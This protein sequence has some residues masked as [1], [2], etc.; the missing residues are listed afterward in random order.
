MINPSIYKTLPFDIFSDFAAV[1][2][3]GI[4]TGYL[5]IVNPKV[6]AEN[7]G[8]F[9]AYA[10]SH[11]V[12]YGSAGIGNTLH[13][14]AELLNAKAGIAMEHVPFRGAGPVL[15]ALLGGTIDAAF[16]TPSAV[17]EHVESGKLRAIGFTGSV[18]LRELPNVPLI[19]ATVPNFKIE[20]AWHAWLAPG[21]TPS[22]VLERINGEVRAALQV[23]KVRQA[24]QQA[25]YEPTTMA[26]A[27]FATF[28]RQETERYA[29]AVRAAKIE[30]Q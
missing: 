29:Q 13:L 22:A 5:L 12:L 9:V 4:G 21:K 10:K 19:Q 6:P 7:V 24:I 1:A 20:G 28:L 14:T 30:P 18:P 2:P 16:V 23:P 8:E 17:L 26:P 27:E 15:T 11:R 3:L 25:G